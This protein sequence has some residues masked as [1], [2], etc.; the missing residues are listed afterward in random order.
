MDTFF[1]G[2]LA[3]VFVLASFSLTAFA[4]DGDVLV[5][6]GGT[7]YP[8][9]SGGA[10]ADAVVFISGGKIERVATRKELQSGWEKS[11]RVLD[12]TGKVIVAGYWNSHVH[13]ETGW[14]DAANTPAAKLE[15]HMQEMLT[16]WGFTTVWDL[17]SNPWN[18]LTI[19][20][21]VES[22]EVRGARIL[23]AGDIFPKN[24]HPI[25]LPAELQLLEAATPTEAAQD[26]A[27]FLKQG[28][29]GIKLFTG[30]YMGNAKPVVNMDAAIVKA[31]VDVAHA[32]KKPVFTH[33]QNRAGV[34]NGLAG[35]V[36]VL[37][38]TVPTE[39]TFTSDELAQM[40]RQH[41]ALIPTLALWPIVMQGAPQAAVDKML[42]GGENELKQYFSAG[43][44]ILFGTDVG[45]QSEYDPAHEFEYMGQALGWR[46]ILA[47]LTTNPSE[48]FKAETKGRVEQGMDADLVVLDGDPAMD[49][50]NF[51]RVAYTI[52]A[53]KVIY[54][55]AQQSQ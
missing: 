14:A 32:Q 23:M 33:P 2:W 9:P 41:V 39:S 31:A 11:A 25:Y 7:V 4:A 30:S 16:G 42:A 10:V 43:G 47:S 34:D 6:A 36:D 45:F 12:C 29:D 5:L 38:H 55:R 22:G 8:S 15:A 3:F 44:T 52:R 1:K 48:F 46:D 13:F 21:R 35:G 51:G 18:T 50:R 37:A 53:G 19:R 20:R 24:G 27:N 26:A 40:K 28:L 17:G 49:V 54:A